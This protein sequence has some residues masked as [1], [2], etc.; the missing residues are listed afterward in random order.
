MVIGL[1]YPI[2]IYQTRYMLGKVTKIGKMKGGEQ[3]AKTADKSKYL[4]L[5]SEMKRVGVTQ[6]QVAEH[7][8]MSQS[9]LNAKLNGR[10][11]FTVPEVVDIRET[12]MP[13]ATLD[14]LLATSL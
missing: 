2:D 9:N 3:M 10:V 5:I 8:D 11:P 12:F 4:N 13:D 7:L 1:N 14:Y 6:S